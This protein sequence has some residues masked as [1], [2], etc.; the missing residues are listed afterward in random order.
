MSLFQQKVDFRQGYGLTETS[1]TVA[2]TPKSWTKSYSS[3]GCPVP[4]TELRIVDG[5]L[6]NLGPNEVR[7]DDAFLTSP[8]HLKHA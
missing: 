4:S 6:K 2:L 8:D 1:P 5:D 7:N 3:T